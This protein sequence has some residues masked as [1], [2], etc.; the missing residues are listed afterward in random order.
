MPKKFAFMGRSIEEI[1]KMPLEEFTKLL[2]ARQRRT[3]KRGLV[4]KQKVFFEK[5]KKAKLGRYKKPIKTHVRDI[6]VL[7]EMLGLTI[8]IHNGKEFIPV[9]INPEMLGH[10][11]GEFA[12]TRR[13]VE[14]SAPGLGATKSSSAMAVK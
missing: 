9:N 12:L 10:L 11:L 2:P 14:H 8:H 1:E 7:P 13:K 4:Q 5:I 6:I 3:I